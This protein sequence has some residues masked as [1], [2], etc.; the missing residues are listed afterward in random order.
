MQ[1]STHTIER[2][3]ALFSEYV[4]RFVVCSCCARFVTVGITVYEL[5]QALL[6]FSTHLAI[7]SNSA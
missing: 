5:S 4:P 1:S 7:Y 2:P 3:G 6:Q